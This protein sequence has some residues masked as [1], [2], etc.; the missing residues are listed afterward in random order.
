MRDSCN[1]NSKMLVTFVI[2]YGEVTSIF[3]LAKMLLC[4][5]RFLNAD[6]AAFGLNPHI[7]LLKIFDVSNAHLIRVV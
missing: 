6:A 1:V 5:H 3:L 7:C 2:P 4:L